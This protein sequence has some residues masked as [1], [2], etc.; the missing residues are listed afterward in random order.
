VLYPH[1]DALRALAVMA[2]VLHHTLPIASDDGFSP[3]ALGPAGVRLF[4]VL[5]GFLISGILLN[6]RREAEELGQAP[7]GVLWPFLL[8]RGLRIFPL[9]FATI[10]GMW[11][12]GVLEGADLVA[13]LTYAI[14]IRVAATGVWPPALGHFWS[15]AI[16]EQ[17]YLVWPF[18]ILLTPSRYLRPVMVGAIVGSGLL[19]TLLLPGA[20]LAAFV[21]TPTRLDA[22]AAGGLL[23]TG[24]LPFRRLV[25]WG[26]A[27]AWGGLLLAPVSDGVRLLNEWVGIG[28]A[29]A[30]VSAGREGF[31]GW[32]GSLASARPVQS[33]GRLAYG[34]YVYHLVIPT[35]IGVVEHRFD[36][37]LR[38]P[39]PGV[40]QLLYVGVTTL[41]VAKLSY[42]YFEAPLTGLKRYIPYVGVTRPSPD[43]VPE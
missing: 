17:F 7:L 33:V 38:L 41:I 14:N 28:L 22:L 16:E 24:Q 4:F 29:L 34:I 31:S 3:W 8:R 32:W 5:S 19:R 13:A 40:G 21:L 23:A 11:A 27:L 9:A 10:A 12:L 43:F 6:A 42:T 15:L 20:P 37:W 18:V 35:S 30:L 2:V 39:P 1:L 25:G 36:I 26:C